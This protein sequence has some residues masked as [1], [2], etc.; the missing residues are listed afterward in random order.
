MPNEVDDFLSQVKGESKGDP[1]IADESDPLA[2]KGE[3]TKSEI[4]TDKVEDDTKPLPFHKDPKVQRYIEREIGKRIKDI[5]PSEV[6]QFAK[7]VGVSEDELTDT[8]VEII[9]ND[10]PQK[11]AAVKKFRSQLEGLKKAGAQEALSEIRQQAEADQAEQAEAVEEINEAFDAIEEEFDVDLT[12][13]TTAARKERNDFIDF[14]KRVSPKDENGDVM[15]YPDFQET[16][17]LFQSTKKPS[18]DNKRAKDIA[19]RS[20]TRSTDSGSAPTSGKSWKDI[21]RI[22]SKL[23]N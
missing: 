13:N 11:V 19:S 23:P 20:M 6:Q 21:D 5:K 15:Q 4:V 16:W 9:G 22:W 2:S 8:L 18:T 14:V 3:G 17:K 7:E 1:F 10:T 12:S